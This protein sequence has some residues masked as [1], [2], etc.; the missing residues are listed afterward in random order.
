VGARFIR[1]STVIALLA[2]LSA[3]AA[4][5]Q[6]PVGLDSLSSQSG[7]PAPTDPGVRLDRVILELSADAGAHAPARSRT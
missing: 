6:D 4:S 7:T 2:G 3:A 1:L 5:A